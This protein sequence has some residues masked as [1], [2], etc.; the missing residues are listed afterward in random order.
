ML[1]PLEGRKPDIGTLGKVCLSGFECI[2][3]FTRVCATG[4]T[5]TGPATVRIAPLWAASVHAGDTARSRL[6]R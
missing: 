2:P 4:V 1:P 6:S 3:S 5:A